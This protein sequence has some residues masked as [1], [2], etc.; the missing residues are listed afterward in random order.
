MIL[1]AFS[2][3]R[4]LRWTICE[5]SF[6]FYTARVRPNSINVYFR[7]IDGAT[8]PC[9][10]WTV[11]RFSGAFSDELP[12][13]LCDIHRSVGIPLASGVV[14]PVRSCL[15]RLKSGR[16]SRQI[17]AFRSVHRRVGFPVAS[18]VVV[19][20]VTISFRRIR[21]RQRMRP[22]IMPARIRVA[23]NAPW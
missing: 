20:M 1:E 17:R 11:L 12:E 3:R 14:F 18:V 4:P 23:S 8:F 21:I 5:S 7:G 9:S 10:S 19:R 16:T 13:H 22:F 2:I 15:Q 6:A